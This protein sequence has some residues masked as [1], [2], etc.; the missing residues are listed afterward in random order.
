MSKVAKKRG[1]KPK[2][3]GRKACLIGIR[4]TPAVYAAY[5][6]AAD[7]RGMTVSEWARTV[8]AV[9]VEPVAEPEEAPK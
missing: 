3:A 5:R 2:G 4:T 1:P 8:L 7:R 9:A 6:A